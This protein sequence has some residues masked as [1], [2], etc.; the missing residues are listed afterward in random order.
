MS[1]RG[2]IIVV[3]IVAAVLLA[4]PFALGMMAESNVRAQIAQ[5]NDYPSG[6]SFE[7][8]GYERGWLASRATVEVSAGQGLFQ[9]I[10]AKDPSIAGLADQMKAPFIL[11]L[12]HGPILTLNGFEIGSYAVK[13]D[14]DPDVQWVQTV[15]NMLD[16]PYLFEL[17]GH[18]GIGSGFEFEGEIPPF[19]NASGDET[20]SFSGLQFSG[21]K[22][23]SDLTLDAGIDRF[24]VQGPAESVSAEGLAYNGAY[25]IR[26][27]TLPLGSWKVGAD[28]IATTN[29]LL[30]ADAATGIDGFSLLATTGLN[31][32]GNVDIGITYAVDSIAVPAAALPGVTG[33][34]DLKLGFKLMNIDSKAVDDFYA[35]IGQMYSSGSDPSLLMLQ[36]LPT[37]NR[38]VAAGPSVALDPVQFSMDGGRLQTSLM[39]SL[40][41]TALPTGQVMDLMDRAVLMDALDAKLEL[42]ASKTLVNDI[43]MLSLREQ[44]GPQLADMPEDQA[45]AMLSQQAAQ[46]IQL[47]VGQGLLADNGDTYS[48][49]VTFA[50]GTATVNGTP[51]PLEALGLL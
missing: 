46:S 14:L 21:R 39:V 22:S 5:L 25:R 1:K 11:E 38:V 32:A 49:T 40:D 45:E 33:L 41:P 23:A 19:E 3:G 42:T 10:S 30:G 6:L 26:P 37:I 36:M 7:I 35:M 13:A 44:M 50:D 31:D 16:V 8:T 28:R 27:G 17:R 20:F 15:M 48:T 4:A 18:T 12:G 34:G 51:F 2:P 47:I 24:S 29:P 43:V 9:M